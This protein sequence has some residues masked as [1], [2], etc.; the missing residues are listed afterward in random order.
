MEISIKAKYNFKRI[1]ALI[2]RLQDSVGIEEVLKNMRGYAIR[3]EKGH[4]ENGILVEMI[5]SKG[6][7][8]GR[9]YANPNEFMSNGISYLFFEYY[10]TGSKAELPHVGTTKHFIESGYTQWFIPV[11]K[12]DRELH[13]P[14]VTIQG[15]DFYV[16]HG[17]SANHFLEDAE[18]QSRAENRDIVKNKLKEMIKE[19]CS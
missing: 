5:N 7:S 14:I 11:N 2:K 12:V 8:K 9:L 13:Y 4:N 16:A 6:E 17:V 15:F 19:V 10:G 18:F 1:D 3:L